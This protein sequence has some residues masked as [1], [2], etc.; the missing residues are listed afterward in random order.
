MASSGRESG[1]NSAGTAWRPEMDNRSPGRGRTVPDGRGWPS[2]AS[3][4]PRAPA[5]TRRARHGPSQSPRQRTIR[6]C[7]RPPPIPPPA[8]SATTARC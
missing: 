5:L 8:S 2:P 6:P 4:S 7:A 3:P 1:R